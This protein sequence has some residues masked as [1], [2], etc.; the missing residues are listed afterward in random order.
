MA[1]EPEVRKVDTLL[2]LTAVAPGD[3]LLIN[4]ISETNLAELTKLIQMQN[5]K[6][7]NA[8][9]LSANIVE[10][11]AIKSGAVT[12]D[13]I[14][15]RTIKGTNIGE[16][17]VGVFE[18]ADSVVGENHLRKYAGTEAVT[19]A[20]IRDGNVTPSKTS[21]MPTTTVDNTVPRFDSTAGKLQ[22]SGVTIGDDNRITTT[23]TGQ[24]AI[25]AK[26]KDETSSNYSLLCRNSAGTTILSARND[27]RVTAPSFYGDITKANSVDSD[28]YVDGSIDYEHLNGTAGSEAVS[29]T[30]IRALAVT[31]EKINNGAVTLAKMAANSVDSDQYV[32]GSI[33][34]VHLAPGV[35]D[36]EASNL[37]YMQLFQLDEAIITTDPKAYFF[38]PSHLV[39][40]KVKKL[41]IGI[42]APSTDVTVTVA[43]GNGTYGSVSGTTSAE[44]AAVNY[45]LPGVFT[46]IPVK[47]TVSAGAI[48][49]GLDFW[50][51]VGK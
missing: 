21:F 23:T 8:A 50:F 24:Y 3:K 18:I 42:V 49:K 6:L 39:G 13:K 34:A 41:G 35:V 5:I 28:Q 36:A 9:Q 44:S 43:L 25:V 1:D 16:G 22:T 38:V 15:S 11:A 33:D 31:T 46:K 7:Y 29:T 48:P 27:G 20:T 45:S 32:D 12:Y 26:G 47:V 40:K 4:D 14:A 30:R 10:N 19:T 51:V 17:Q 2:E 37:I